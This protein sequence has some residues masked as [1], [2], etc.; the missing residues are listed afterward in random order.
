MMSKI[1]ITPLLKKN[2]SS[3]NFNSTKKVAYLKSKIVR[4]K[5]AVKI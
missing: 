4:A 5:Q 2:V 1:N 3:S